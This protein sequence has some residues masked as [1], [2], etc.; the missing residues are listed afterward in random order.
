MYQVTCDPI[1]NSRPAGCSRSGSQDAPELPADLRR[2]PSV[3]SLR[4]LANYAW[5]E[6]SSVARTLRCRCAS[7]SQSL[8][9]LK[10]SRDTKVRPVVS[11]LHSQYHM[12]NSPRQNRVASPG[13]ERRTLAQASP[14]GRSL[15]LLRSCL[16]V[17][18]GSGTPWARIVAA[19]RSFGAF[20]ALLIQVI[21]R[22]VCF[23]DLFFGRYARAGKRCENRFCFV[24]VHECVSSNTSRASPAVAMN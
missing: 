1:V 14:A 10:P 16:P 19:A 3:T 6:R 2:L 21:R 7:F 11:S 8:M 24:D 18:K 12:P 5:S 4:L 22:L 9:L 20:L 13:I 17:T 15:A 23:C